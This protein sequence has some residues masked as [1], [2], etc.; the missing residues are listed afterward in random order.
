[1]VILVTGGMGFIGSHTVQALADL[2]HGC[3]VTSHRTTRDLGD[4]ISI[5]QVDVA[6]RDAMLRLGDRHAIDGIV[7]LA[8][9]ALA[10]LGDLRA[11][12]AM[13][14]TDMRAGADALFN[15]LECA[16]AWDV[17]RVTVAS[18]IGV[19]GGAPDLR[20][21]P[22]DLP[23]QM[24]AGGNVVAASKKSAELVV[25][26]FREHG[27]DAISV[28]LAA[29]WGPRG[30]KE[31]RFYAAPGLIHAAVNGQSPSTAYAGDAI[32]MLYVKDCARAIALLQTAVRLTHST[33]NVGSGRPTSNTDVVTAIKR[34]VPGAELPLQPGRSPHGAVAYLDTTRLQADTGF[35]PEYDLDRAV[36]DYVRWITNDQSQHQTRLHA[37]AHISPSSTAQGVRGKRT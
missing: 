36:P 35:E 12:P 9:P 28:R 24:T 19:Y 15:A 2:G 4:T 13:L 26:L 5:E 14:I 6:D 30:R 20:G 16:I 27:V 1:M 11:G 8:D 29:V 25:S 22:E 21:A 32:D 10:H 17:H 31:S 23:L 18:T 33:Y 7:H 37:T 34:A 3:V